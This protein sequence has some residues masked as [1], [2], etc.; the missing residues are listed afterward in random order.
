MNHYKYSELDTGKTESF[1][2]TVTGQ[3]MESFCNMSGDVNPMHSSEDYAL[4]KGFSGRLVY[5]MLTASFYST[6]VGVY[7]P[8]EHCLFQEAD[9][10]FSKP[11]YIG[12][13]LTIT[14]EITEKL[15]A[16]KRLTIKAKIRN[17]ENKPVSSAVLKVG[18]TDE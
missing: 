8:G 17:Q 14:G 2:V 9:I 1:C 16:Y 5:G 10:K 13:T 18:L 15:D 7:L 3:M 6:L 4:S 12:D 11:V